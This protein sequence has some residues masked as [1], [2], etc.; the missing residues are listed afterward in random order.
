V[1]TDPDRR[2]WK[3]KLEKKFT[4]GKI[5]LTQNFSKKLNFLEW[6]WCVC[7]NFLHLWRK[8]SDPDPD[9]LVRGTYPGIRIRTKMSR[10]PNT[11]FFN[12]C[13]SFLPSWIRIRKTGTEQCA[14]GTAPHRII[15]KQE[16]GTQ[17]ERCAIGSECD[18][19]FPTHFSHMF[20][21]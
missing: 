10:V 12:F 9:P 4:N 3:T 14:T 6:R 20:S 19:V 8:E 13:W 7:M 11:A 1:N 17:R 16:I 5:I 2:F 21:P 18:A 15:F